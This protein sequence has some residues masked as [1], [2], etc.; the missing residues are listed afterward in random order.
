M[1]FPLR[2]KAEGDMTPHPPATLSSKSSELG[3]SL[4][5]T[6]EGMGTELSMSR[7]LGSHSPPL[8]GGIH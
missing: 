5:D 8:D 6:P 1:V 7:D 2:G 3:D 4:S